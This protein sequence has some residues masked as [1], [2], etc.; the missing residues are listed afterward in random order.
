[1]NK[2]LQKTHIDSYFVRM[3]Q[4]SLPSFHL[5]K[6]NPTYDDQDVVV[7]QVST[8]NNDWIVAEIVNKRDYMFKED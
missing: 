3:H 6:E 2:T 8:T 5:F 4:E 1:M 7:L